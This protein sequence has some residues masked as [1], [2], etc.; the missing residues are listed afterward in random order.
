M[1]LAILC[2]AIGIA[3]IAA[4]AARAD[5]V[6]PNTHRVTRCVTIQ[7]AAQFP[8]IT[9]IEYDF[10]VLSSTGQRYIVNRDS[11]L[12]QGYHCIYYVLWAAKSY[13][14]SVGIAN[15]PVPQFITCIRSPV[16][17]LC[18]SALHLLSSTII[19]ND[20]V[21]Y[22]AVSTMTGEDLF[23]SLYTTNQTIS[24]YLS[25]EVSHF[26]DGSSSTQTFLPPAGTVTPVPR[27]SRTNAI[28][29][30]TAAR[31]LFTFKTTFSGPL[32]MT[33][34]D[35][36]GRTVATYYKAC[37]PGCTYITDLSVIK[38]GMYWI[39]LR[40]PNINMVRR[41]AILR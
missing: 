10:S 27:V 37:A 30:I 35:C 36:R 15:L 33:I 32:K 38:A 34:S 23:Y 6:L 17:S 21:V 40:T 9:V 20:S 29:T 7:N 3:L 13:V 16:D 22:D 5:V 1:K 2:A 39:S 31:G 41:L 14:D 4:V 8:D 24:L 25:K 18:T 12:H 26:S 11:C 19:T 28:E